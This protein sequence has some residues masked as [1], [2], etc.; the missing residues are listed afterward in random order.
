MTKEYK[1]LNNGSF[2]H[3]NNNDGRIKITVAKMFGN[4]AVWLEAVIITR[5]L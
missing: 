2:S 3:K 4:G 5:Y 1:V